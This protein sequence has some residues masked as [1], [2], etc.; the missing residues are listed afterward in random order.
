MKHWAFAPHSGGVKIPEST[1]LATEHRLRAHA[2]EHYRGRYERLDITFRG[3]FCCIDAVVEPGGVPMH[4]CRLRHFAA[5]RWSA[6]FFAY[7]SESYE[8]CCLASGE[9]FGSAEEGF[10]LGAVYLREPAP[11]G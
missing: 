9:M 1:K 7:S 11:H 6:A 8:A 4:L 3:V 2:E 5:D 10:D